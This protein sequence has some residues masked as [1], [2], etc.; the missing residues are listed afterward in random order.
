MTM[1]K[2]D[3]HDKKRKTLTGLLLPLYLVDRHVV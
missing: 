2:L 3:L 1:Y